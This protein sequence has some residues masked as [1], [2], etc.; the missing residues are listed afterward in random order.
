MSI[1]VVDIGSNS[2][3]LVVYEALSRA[4]TVLFNEK[5]SSALGRGVATTGLLPPDG[6]ENA[7]AAH[8][9][10]IDAAVVGRPH[11]A[12]GEEPV[13]VVTVKGR[14]SEA[15]LRAFAAERIAGFKVPVQILVRE[16]LLPRNANGKIMKRE[17]RKLFAA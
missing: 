2:V 17:L 16:E 12:L 7:L 3:R 15:E 1:A 9:A 11:H 14:V 6:V 13:A 4:P 8:P 5:A 10:V